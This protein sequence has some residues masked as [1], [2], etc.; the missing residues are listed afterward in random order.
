METVSIHQA[1]VNL[2]QLLERVELGEEVIISNQ[3]VPIAKLVLFH[4]SS[5]RRNSLGQDQG[6]FTMPDDF[7]APLPG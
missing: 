2:L 6:R 3:G 5:N 1:K 7:N 4:P